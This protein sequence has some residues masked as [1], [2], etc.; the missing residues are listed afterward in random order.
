MHSKIL[1]HYKVSVLIKLPSQ[2]WPTSN[3]F[4]Y[5]INTL[6]NRQQMTGRKVFIMRQT[7]PQWKG[8][9]SFVPR[10]LD[11]AIW[12]GNTDCLRLSFGWISFSKHKTKDLFFIIAYSFFIPK[13][14]PP[15]ISVR[16]VLSRCSTQFS[17]LKF[18]GYQCESGM[19]ISYFE[20]GTTTSQ[21]I[22]I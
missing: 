21:T 11:F 4:P 5:N 9:L 22:I 2:K 19:T 16:R 7:T 8:E 10:G 13:Y 1:H 15:S 20:L 3:F 18:K 17:D 14:W 6:S 12:T